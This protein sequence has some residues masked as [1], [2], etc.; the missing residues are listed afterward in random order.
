M[1]TK[2]KQDGDNDNDR[3]NVTNKKNTKY[4]QI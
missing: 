4:E 3:N 2:I 1:F